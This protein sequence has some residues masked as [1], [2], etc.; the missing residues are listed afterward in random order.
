MLSSCMQRVEVGHYK[1]TLKKHTLVADKQGG[2]VVQK[3]RMVRS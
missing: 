3:G 2:G 1:K